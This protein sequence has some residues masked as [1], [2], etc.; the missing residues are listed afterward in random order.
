MRNAAGRARSGMTLLLLLPALLLFVPPSAEADVAPPPGI[1]E[2]FHDLAIDLGPYGAVM[3]RVHV[4]AKGDTLG[5]LAQRYL[6]TTKRWAEIQEANPGLDPENLTVGST[7]TIPAKTKALAPG[8]AETADGPRHRWDFFT[9]TPIWNA[10]DPLPAN[11][12]IRKRYH[13]GTGLVAVRHDK[14]A[15]FE[16]RIRTKPAQKAEN[17]IR[18]VFSLDAKSRPDWIAVGPVATSTQVKDADPVF[19]VVDTRRIT[20]IR[21]GVI[22][23]ERMHLRKHGK[24]GKVLSEA[25]IVAKRNTTAMI[26]ILLGLVGFVLLVHTTM[27]RRC[28]R[29]VSTPTATTAALLVVL[30]LAPAAS[31][32]IPVPGYRNITTEV[33]LDFGPYAKPPKKG[34]HGWTFYSI[35]SPSMKLMPCA[36]GKKVPV[37]HYGTTVVAVRTDHDAAFRKAFEDK[38]TGSY[39]YLRTLETKPP[40]WF[41][42]AKDIDAGR[43]SVKTSSPVQRIEK[44]VRI[45][46]I[47]KGVIATE[48]AST[49]HFGKD[50][51]KLTAAELKSAEHLNLVLLLLAGGGLLGLIVLLVRRRRPVRAAAAALL[52]GVL[53]LAPAGEATA[54]VSVGPAPPVQFV[55]AVIDFGALRDRCFR[56]TRVEKGQTLRS[57]AK[58]LLG[59][60]ARWH[61]IQALNPEAHPTELGTGYRLTLP[62]KAPPKEGAWRFFLADGQQGRA[63]EIFDGGAASALWT[64]SATLV[65]VRADGVK[66]F[67]AKLK[68]EHETEKVRR[69]LRMVPKRVG[70]ERLVAAP[71]AWFAWAPDVKL[72]RRTLEKPSPL[73]TIKHDVRI[74]GMAAGKLQTRIVR[75]RYL[76]PTGREMTAEEARKHIATREAI[77]VVLGLLGAAGLVWVVLRRHRTE[78]ASAA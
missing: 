71:P 50:G 51:K 74:E 59:D 73:R 65:A 14:R 20:S 63:R 66:S 17:W 55:T 41:A 67:H 5:A 2:Q 78:V 69:R 10:V 24:D 68:E 54:D 33:T 7:L 35:P 38:E 11:G 56:T 60:E 4:V 21:D 25:E 29:L 30:L 13:G 49:T 22:G 34:T 76:S 37:L 3:P 48:V 43:T 8:K 77:F 39:R 16:A 70:L 42:K 40:V 75:T 52:A 12:V 44:T 45:T 31:A 62:A 23:T 64:Q 28:A 27:R 1:R 58:D 15:D 18:S 47:A 9:F 61:E 53:T 6:G 26:F 32:D 19:R 36:H 46:G 72:E 57:I